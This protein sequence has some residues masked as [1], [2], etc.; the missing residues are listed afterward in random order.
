[1]QVVDGSAMDGCW[2]MTHKLGGGRNGKCAPCNAHPAHSPPPTCKEHLSIQ[3][4]RTCGHPVTRLNQPPRAVRDM[5]ANIAHIPQSYLLEARQISTP[6]IL[7]SCRADRRDCVYPAPCTMRFFHP[8]EPRTTCNA[9]EHPASF[10]PLSPLRAA[11]WFPGIDRK[12]YVAT[13]ARYCD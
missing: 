7:Q 12:A 2:E 6:G 10:D 1:M 9:Y 4:A 13:K 8:S 11:F 3:A 5:T